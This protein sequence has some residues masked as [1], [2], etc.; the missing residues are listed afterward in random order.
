VDHVELPPPQETYVKAVRRGE[1]KPVYPSLARA[2][3]IEGE[4]VLTAT[5]DANGV[6]TDA[7]VERSDYRVF[8]QAARDAV[9]RLRYSPALRNGKPEEST[10][11]VTVGFFL[12]R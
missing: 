4:V 11:T 7:R 8:E 6:V 2:N 10:D 1:P 12:D 5:V 3:S 9:M